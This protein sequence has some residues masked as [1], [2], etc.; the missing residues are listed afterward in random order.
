MQVLKPEHLQ[1]SPAGLYGPFFS[2]DVFPPAR[3]KV[4][5]L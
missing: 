4:R 2:G 5:K 3:E 1:F